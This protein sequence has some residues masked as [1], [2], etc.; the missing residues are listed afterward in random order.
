MTGLGL[1]V[2]IFILGPTDCPALCALSVASHIPNSSHTLRSNTSVWSLEKGDNVEHQTS[3][4]SSDDQHDSTR[5][6][7]GPTR[8]CALTLDL[9]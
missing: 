1:F 7:Y 3:F 9:V 2:C 8:R 4:G 6:G 5:R